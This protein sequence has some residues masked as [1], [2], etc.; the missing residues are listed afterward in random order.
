MHTPPGVKGSFSGTSDG[1]LVMWNLSLILDGYAYN[2]ED[3]F[4][5]STAQSMYS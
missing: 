4:E 2:I 1:D 3:S 5:R